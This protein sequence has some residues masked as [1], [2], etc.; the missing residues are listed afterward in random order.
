MT[1]SRTAVR[2]GASRVITPFSSEAMGEEI[3]AI[4]DGLASLAW[5]TGNRAVYFSFGLAEAA[6]VKKAF[7]ENGTVVSGNCCA[8]I[9]DDSFVRKVTTGSTA[10]AG[11]SVPQVVDVTDTL[12]APGRYW[13]AFS[14]DD[15]TGTLM[16]ANPIAQNM[17]A[18]G[19][20]EEASAFPIPD[21]I[22][23]ATP[24]MGYIPVFGFTVETV[25]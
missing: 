12:L 15:T 22:T 14:H 19:I 1:V 20:F 23:P 6:V 16:R 10:Q 7:W 8:A 18:L 4:D 13:L 24:T 17:H 9:C 21:P 25:L 5:V 2:Y 3:A 11:T